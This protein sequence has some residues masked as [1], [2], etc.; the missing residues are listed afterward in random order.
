MNSKLIINGIEVAILNVVFIRFSL[1]LG[2]FGG[3]GCDDCGHGAIRVLMAGIQGQR[4]GGEAG[5][6][7]STGL[8]RTY[9]DEAAGEAAQVDALV[10]GPR[11]E[12]LYARFP[13]MG[14]AQGPRGRLTSNTLL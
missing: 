14:K 2:R 6:Q 5:L 1:F 7:G 12:A 10:E 13:R 8:R 3:R 11:V 4:G 9:A